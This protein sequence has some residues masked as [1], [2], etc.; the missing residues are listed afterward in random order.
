MTISGPTEARVGDPVPLTC[1]TANS[2]PPA[3]IKWM[4]AG[5]QVRNATSRTIV[6]PEGGWITTSN[7]TA[8]VEPNRRSLVVI[9]H[10][11]NMQ[12]TEN[13][14]STHTINVLCKPK[15]LLLL[16]IATTSRFFSFVQ[17]LRANLLSMV[18]RRARVSLLELYRKFPARRQVEIL[19]PH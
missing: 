12:L 5:R 16:N 7:I 2:N 9:C 8:I 3:E 11:L 10:G 18:T 17:I 6:S 4:V 15:Q 14:V 1:T 19:S 13:V